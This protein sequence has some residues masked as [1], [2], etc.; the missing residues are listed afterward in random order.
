MTNDWHGRKRGTDPIE[1]PL[2]HSKE[3]EV[4]CLGAILLDAPK[5]AETIDSLEP[6]DFFLPLHQVIFRHIKRLRSLGMA[7]NDFVLLNDAID[8]SKELEAAGGTSYIASLTDCLY[9]SPNVAQYVEIIK[10]AAKLR[11]AIRISQ[12]NTEKLLA[13]NGDGS[14]VLQ[15]V[16]DSFC[17]LRG[18]VGQ[19]LILNFRTGA[20]YSANEGQGVEWIA[21]GLVAKGAITELGAKV[22]AGKTTLI[23]AMIRATLDGSEF[24]SQPTLKTSVLYLTEQ[25]V[26]SFYQALERAGLLGRQDLSVLHFTDTRGHAWPAVVSEAVTRCKQIGAVLL[27]VDT[28]PQFAGLTGDRENNAGDA[29]EA[30]GPLQ[31][32]AAEGIGVLLVRHERKS[33]GDVGDSAR[34]SSAF[35]GAADIV[36]SLRKPEGNAPKTRRL[37]QSVS[38]FSETL[39]DLLVD[40]THGAYVALGERHETAIKDAK[41]LV[42]AAA[43]QL[44]AEAIDLRELGKTTSVSRVTAQRAVDELVRDGLLNR[45]GEGKRGNPF[46]Y[47]LTERPF[48]PT[49]NTEVAEKETNQNSCRG[50]MHAQQDPD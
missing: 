45:I 40:L 25:P 46:R 23:L 12:L 44:E 36:L 28:L 17:P 31:A 50:H 21:R 33:G 7:T 3:A 4:A 27:V 41:D 22:K 8:Q 29:L 10:R 11:A 19:K 37:L 35:A 1:R 42:F 18:V 47:F 30:M 49:S 39:N 48:C 15:A 5:A 24:L 43:P 9:R 14:T 6:G 13:V 34:G 16:F 26:S 20:D 38:R 2:P 32:A